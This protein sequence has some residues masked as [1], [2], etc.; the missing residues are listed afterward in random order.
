MAKDEL[1]VLLQVQVLLQI[2]L[3]AEFFW[4]SERM[5]LLLTGGHSPAGP[6]IVEI[7]LIS[8]STLIAGNIATAEGALFY[9]G[10]YR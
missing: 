7:Q 8:R 4:G 9:G 2:H 3:N 10:R 1:V 5:R 6:Q